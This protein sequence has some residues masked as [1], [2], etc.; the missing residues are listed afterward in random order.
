MEEAEER[1]RALPQGFA[2]SV[3]KLEIQCER[4]DATK[5]HVNKLVDLYTVTL[6]IYILRLLLNTITIW[7]KMTIKHFSSLN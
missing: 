6:S 1:R 5:E 7:V 3:I 4:P 2:Q